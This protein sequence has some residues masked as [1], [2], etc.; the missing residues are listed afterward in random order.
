LNLVLR[1]LIRSRA[2]SAILLIALVQAL[3]ATASAQV[4]NPAT[5]Q[6]P[7]APADP[8][9]DNHHTWEMPPIDVRGKAPLEEEDLIGDYEQP[10]WTAHRRFGETRVYVIPKGMVDFEYWLRP[11]V[12]KNGPTDF[13]NMYEVEFGLP[14]RLQLDLYAV[15]NKSGQE[16]TL[17]ID[18]QKVELRYAFADWG[19]LWGNPT[20][21]V[22]WTQNSNGPDAIEGKLLLGGELTS[23]WHWGSNFVFE[24]VIAGAQE[25]SHEWTTGLSYTARDTKLGVGVETQLA[26]VNELEANGQRG[27]MTTAFLAGPSLQ[28]RPLAQMHLDV[29]P[30]LGFNRA[31]PRM[32][33][34][35]VLGY[36]F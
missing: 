15:G 29:A 21:Y 10:R 23:R 27:P 6:K 25:N 13:Q 34:F 11:T 30:L 24:H 2:A 28:W 17:A 12:N 35:V 5:A 33:L 7:D 1:R 31:A 32:K 16:G 8:R 36:E 14:G 19:K 22:E 9:A 26:L 4:V 3:V 18:Q 20:M